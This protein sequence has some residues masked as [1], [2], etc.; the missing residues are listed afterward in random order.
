MAVVVV[1][2]GGNQS[3]LSHLLTY[4]PSVISSFEMIDSLLKLLD[5][6]DSFVC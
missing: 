6:Y 5:S 4:S 1:L 3:E 2:G